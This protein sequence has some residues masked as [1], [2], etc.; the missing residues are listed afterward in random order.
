MAHNSN[1]GTTLGGFD[2]RSG[3]RDQRRFSAT[4]ILLAGKQRMCS[5][6]QHQRTLTTCFFL[7]ATE[8]MKLLPGSRFDDGKRDLAAGEHRL[9]GTDGATVLEAARCALLGHRLRA[10]DEGVLWPMPEEPGA[11]REYVD[12]LLAPVPLTGMSQTVTS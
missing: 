6:K 9:D 7:P 2:G 5:W 8:L 4:V 1:Y 11:D 3:Q 12:P 10:F